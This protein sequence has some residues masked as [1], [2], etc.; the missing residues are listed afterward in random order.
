MRKVG[1]KNPHWIGDDPAW[2]VALTNG[3]IHKDVTRKEICAAIKALKKAAPE[4][5]RY[6][7]DYIDVVRN[8]HFDLYNEY[9]VNYKNELE[10]KH[11]TQ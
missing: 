9:H 6:H 7:D 3:E 2:D 10:V 5:V 1:T 4:R 8:F 11:E